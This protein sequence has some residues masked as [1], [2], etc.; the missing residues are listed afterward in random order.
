MIGAPAAQLAGAHGRRRSRQAHLIESVLAETSSF[1][2]AQDLYA[3]LRGG[4]ST[5]GLTTIYRCLRALTT[6][7]DVD[8]VT[9]ETGEALYRGRGQ[10]QCEQHRHFI[11]C[12]SCRAAVEIA[13][14]NI[15]RWVANTG[16]RN[17]YQQLT[18]RVEIFGLCP[19]CSRARSAT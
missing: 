18:H 3:Q 5:I 4:G 2:S 14:P 1:L 11:I 13:S 15:E 6:S 19:A 16:R 7:G 17:R 8:V 10:S 12:R 9:S